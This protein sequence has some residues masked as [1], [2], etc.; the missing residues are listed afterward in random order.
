MV[1]CLAELLQVTPLEPARFADAAPASPDLFASIPRR[2]GRDGVCHGHGVI[3]QDP[4][5][6][7]RQFVRDTRWPKGFGAHVAFGVEVIDDEKAFLCE[8]MSGLAARRS[9]P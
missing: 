5:H 3:H 1:V 8:G 7:A 4:S 9:G 2:T 6:V